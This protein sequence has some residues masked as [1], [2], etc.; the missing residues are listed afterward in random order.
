MNLEITELKILPCHKGKCIAD[1]L[2]TF[3]GNMT[4]T[5]RIRETK[6]GIKVYYPPCIGFD[7]K[8][9]QKQI[10]N[11][12]LANYVINYCVDDYNVNN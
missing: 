6:D 3:N 7:S 1:I 8:E 9:T 4:I 10:D 11:R 12:I 2:A 5:A